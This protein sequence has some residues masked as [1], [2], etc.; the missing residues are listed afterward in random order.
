MLDRREEPGCI[1]LSYLF[2]HLSSNPPPISRGHSKDGVSEGL[3]HQRYLRG[4]GKG[5]AVVTGQGAN[6][7]AGQPRD[8]TGR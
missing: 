4:P 3:Y 5:E 8:P 6:T 1:T 2:P 7:Q